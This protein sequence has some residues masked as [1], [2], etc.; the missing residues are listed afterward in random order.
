MIL[1]RQLTDKPEVLMRAILNTK[2]ILG[3]SRAAS[4]FVPEVTG[5]NSDWD[6]Y[7]SGDLF[8]VLGFTAAL[9]D[10]GV[11]WTAMGG[12]EN[13]YNNSPGTGPKERPNVLRGTLMDGDM[14]HSIQVMWILDCPASHDILN[15]HSSMVQCFVSGFQATAL[16]H[17]LIRRQ[18][19]VHWGKNHH[20]TPF[21]GTP[22]SLGSS[23]RL[24]DLQRRQE[25]TRREDFS[26]SHIPQSIPLFSPSQESLTSQKMPK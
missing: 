23:M 21:T 3:R 14:C 20:T 9:V 26:A 25:S 16:Y 1:L 10:L 17:E 15:Y 19:C 7:T 22:M 6:L 2:A 4:I 8:L 11:N 13:P 18:I 12:L 24:R 5:I